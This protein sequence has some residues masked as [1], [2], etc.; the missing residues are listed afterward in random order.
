MQ[1]SSL[2]V[3]TGTDGTRIKHGLT[4]V[5][6]RGGIAA[7][8]ILSRNSSVYHPRLESQGFLLRKRVGMSPCLAALTESPPIL[9][10]GIIT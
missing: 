9:D 2:R 1:Q 10:L 3:F 7:P 5:I 4:R 6:A 8:K